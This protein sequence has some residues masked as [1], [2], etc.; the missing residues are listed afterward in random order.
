MTSI[1]PYTLRTIEAGRFGLD[2]GAMFGI[3]PKPLWERR[4]PADSKNR[5]PLNMRC[6]LIEGEGRLMLVDNGLGDKYDQ[7]FGSIFGVDTEYAELHRSLHAAGV[8]AEDI[9]DVIITHLHFDHCG[10]T[11]SRDGDALRMVFKNATHHVQ[12]SHWEWA[13][14]PNIRER[15]SFLK[16]NLEPMGASGQLRL[17]SGTAEIAP[18]I[19]VFAVSGHTEGMQLVKLSDGEH[20]LVYAADLIPT[21]AHVP[22]AW[23][24]AYDIH[25]LKTIQEKE[26]VLE[27]AVREG[28]SL[29]L[30]HDPE[31]EVIS[32]KRS[33]R[34]IAVENPRPLKELK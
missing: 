2:G 20:T 21:H 12:K 5:I 4:I 19:E 1:G 29:F 23:N 31:V 32:L 10:G 7:K 34:G 6:L 9:T 28:W 25:P 8:S 30:E 22:M 13:Q 26:V 17:L 15:N 14:V 11:T 16:E 33:D 3:V 27:Q 24:M 18:G